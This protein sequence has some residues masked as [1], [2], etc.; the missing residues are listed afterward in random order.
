MANIPAGVPEDV[1]VIASS[2]LGSQ[3]VARRCDNMLRKIIIA[4]DDPQFCYAVGKLL[5][6]AGFA[7]DRYLGSTEAWPFVGALAKFDLLLTDIMFPKGQPTGLALGRS[8]HFHHPGV[9]VIYMTAYAEAAALV[10]ADGETVLEKPVDLAVLL[11]KVEELLAAAE[12]D[13]WPAA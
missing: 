10:K 11:L 2:E 6:G 8:A 12:R 5:E 9:P 3:Y 13:L 1:F 4:D 7:V